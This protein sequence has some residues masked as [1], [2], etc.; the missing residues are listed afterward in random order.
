MLLSGKAC[1]ADGAGKPVCGKLHQ[2]TIVVLVGYDRR[3]RPGL[4]AVSRGKRRSTVKKISATPAGRWP[5][6]LRDFLDRS[7]DDPAIDQC[8]GSQQ[9][10]LARAIVMGRAPKQVE[11]RSHAAG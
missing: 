3:Q 7:H 8:F 9:A 11:G 2:R 1:N 6:T 5:T 10:G 4:D